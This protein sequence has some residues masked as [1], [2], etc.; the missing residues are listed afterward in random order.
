MI[1]ISSLCKIYKS[2][3]RKTCYALKDIT[4]TLPDAGLVFVLGKSG[5][6]KSTL[7][8]LIGGLDAITSGS[9]RVDG[10]DLS[11][12]NEREL[13][14]YRNTHIGFIF[15]DYHLIDEL[16]V[17]DNI[18][19]SLDLLEIK[20][21]QLVTDA[22]ERV[23]LAGYD[24]RYPSELSGGEQQRVAIARALVKRPKIILADEPTGNLDTETANDIIE[25]LR[26]AARDCLILIV[27]HNVNDANN[28]A[29]RIIRL[30]TGTVIED[31]TRNP[32]FSNEITLENNTLVYPDGIS[33]SDTDI[34]L[35]NNNK[36]ANLVK[37]V[38]KFLPTLDD[39][40][41][42]RKV[43]VEK[44]TLPWRQKI[45]LS[46]LFLKRKRF[47]I[48]ASAFMLAM[49]MLIFSLAQTMIAFDS[50]KM[51][52]DEMKKSGV[53][54]M[55]LNKV[56]NEEQK[57]YLDQNYRIPVPDSDIEAIRNAGYQGDIYPV[58]SLTVSVTSFNASYTGIGDSY[59]KGTPY[60]TSGLGT[61]VVDEEFLTKKFGDFEWAAKVDQFIPEG[62]VITDYLADAILAANPNYEGKTYQDLLQEYCVLPR[63]YHRMYINGIIYTGYREQYAGLLERAQ[64]R[65]YNLATD[66][67]FRAFLEDVYDRLGYTY[68]TNPDFEQEYIN[69][70]LTDDIFGYKFN[71][72]NSVD[73]IDLESPNV[74]DY[75][76]LVNSNGYEFNGQWFYTDKCPAIPEGAKYIRV[77]YHDGCDDLGYTEDARFA[78]DS[79]TL[80]FSDGTYASAEEL[81]AYSGYLINAYDG[82]LYDAT[83]G[84]FINDYYSLEQDP[85]LYQTW[86]KVSDYIEIPE[87][88]TITEFLS[89]T[90][91]RY[92][93]CAFYDENKIFIDATMIDS[94]NHL[95][96]ASMYWDIEDYNNVFGTEYTMDTLGDFVPHKVLLTHY[97]YAD[98]NNENP[99]FSKEVTI[100][101]L[102][103][104]S[105]S[106]DIAELF[107]KDIIQ[108]YSLYLDGTEGIGG[109]FD[110][111]SS[112]S[113]EHQNWASESI[114]TMTKVM[115]VFAPIFELVRLFMCCAIILIFISFSNKMIKSK[116]H[117][118]GILKA[119]GT[120]N[121]HILSIFGIQVMLIAL[122]TGIFSTIG[123]V[124][125]IDTANTL[126]TDAMIRFNPNQL[127]SELQF[128][129]FIPGVAI[130]N[131]L[132][133]FA[134]A[135]VSLIPP[136][137][138]IKLIQPVKI[139][140]TKE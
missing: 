88:T 48:A 104:R 103:A 53:S 52:Q 11:S 111:L 81:N 14:D 43:R 139:I 70:Y 131:V 82:T 4:L 56:P 100:I 77:S 28:Y 8:N 130:G 1:K 87:G 9:I 84:L 31:R 3:K 5:S 63:Y 122:L 55:W 107:K 72:N 30:K 118:I 69:S 93:S 83:K 89:I 10:N 115:D 50:N 116:M 27:S 32:E 68:A 90:S 101:G 75:N 108:T 97:H 78:P 117:E 120:K 21:K 26:E 62:L 85:E 18:A 40:E 66:E 46:G 137:I 34:D 35:I 33:L 132:L 44:K 114:Y 74:Y 134:L 51:L 138:K 128:L 41:E 15:Q 124:F 16:T 76:I 45:R 25:L 64:Q 60:L 47:A 112:L 140:K 37:R 42:E 95:P 123:Y 73:I 98:T 29:D 17:F 12:L 61:L 49:I 54:S 135:F 6:G 96:E 22:L 23:G 92:A 86:T 2:K 121:G 71:F 99:L 24:D 65:G 106:S 133:V 7:L 113:F 102:G 58:L 19:I 38:D 119:L 13:C 136:M 127:I 39:Q 91:P 79:A 94:G 125:F 109:V 67:E 20:D 57:L 80:V 36:A 126:L 105:V 129:D 59:F 110:L